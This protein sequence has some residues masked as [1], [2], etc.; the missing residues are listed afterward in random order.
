[1]VL[2]VVLLLGLA[3]HEIVKD[4]EFDEWLCGRHATVSGLRWNE[5]VELVIE[6][7]QELTEIIFVAQC[8][9]AQSL[10]LNVIQDTLG[11]WVQDIVQLFFCRN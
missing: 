1:M 10:V 9:Q 8:R 4:E 2:S 7:F 6:L 5:T 11:Q 3:L